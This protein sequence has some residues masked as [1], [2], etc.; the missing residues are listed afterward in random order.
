MPRRWTL[1]LFMREINRDI[2]LIYLPSASST[3][4]CELH[5]FLVVRLYC[6]VPVHPDRARVSK[7]LCLYVSICYCS[8]C[9]H[10]ICSLLMQ[11]CHS[12]IIALQSWTLSLEKFKLFTLSTRFLKLGS[13]DTNLW[14]PIHEQSTL[15]LQIRLQILSY[16]EANK[17]LNLI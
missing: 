2:I 10:C 6:S 7:A 12:S 9:L 4:V 13:V 15:K 8:V 16:S 1:V 14:L 5:F 11:L 3:D 17:V